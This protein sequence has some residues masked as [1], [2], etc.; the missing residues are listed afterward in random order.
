MAPL[1][2]EFSIARF[3]K[4]FYH[5]RSFRGGVCP[6]H[7]PPS[8]P[9]FRSALPRFVK[10]CL[11]AFAIIRSIYAMPISLNTKNQRI[12]VSRRRN[13]NN[14]I[15]TSSVLLRSHGVATGRPVGPAV[16]RVTT[17]RRP[18]TTT[19]IT[20]VRLSLVGLNSRN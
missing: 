20:K 13:I 14:N 3:I 7:H 2:S 12:A 6:A 9:F 5:T 18:S 19:T 17:S 1:K 15:K 11:R 10:I 4:E 8:T 16:R